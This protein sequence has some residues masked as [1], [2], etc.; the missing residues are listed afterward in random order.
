MLFIN[1]NKYALAGCGAISLYNKTEV[2]IRLQP[3][4][5]TKKRYDA[6]VYR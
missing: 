4:I 2:G 5:L 1:I 3:I 6:R